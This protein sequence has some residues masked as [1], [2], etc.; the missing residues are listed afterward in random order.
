MGQHLQ[1]LA[2]GRGADDPPVMQAGDQK[3]LGIHQQRFRP[4][5]AQG[6][7]T[8]DVLQALVFAVG[9]I[10][11]RGCLGWC[12]VDRLHLGGHQQQEGHDDDQYQ[13]QQVTDFLIHGVSRG[14]LEGGVTGS[15]CNVP[16]R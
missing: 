7:D 8:L 1:G 12:P 3:P 6:T 2:V 4:V 5:D 14:A 11:Q 13:E 16:N 15:Q 10:L 9:P